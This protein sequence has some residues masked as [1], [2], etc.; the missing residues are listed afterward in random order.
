MSEPTAAAAH[1][2]DVVRPQTSR[3]N[4]LLYGVGTL[5][6]DMTYTL[7]AFFLI[8][9]LTDVV[10]VDNRTLAW[11]TGLLLTVRL[12]DAVLDPVIGALVDSTRTRWGQFKPWMALGGLVSGV[13]TILLFT[14]FGLTGTQFVVVFSLLNLLWGIGW[15]AHDISYWGLLP[16]LSLNPQDRERNAATAKVFASLGQFTVV[17]GVPVVAAGIAASVGGTERAWQLVAIGCSLAMV[18]TMGITIFGVRERTDVDLEGAHTGL[19]EL[20][21]A[22]FRND[23]LIWA[24]TAYLLFMVGYGL[25]GAFGLYFFKYAYGDETVFSVFVIF[26]GIGQVLG[27]ASFPALVRRFGRRR[28]YRGATVVI[29][30][31]FIAFA[32]APLN[33]L[34]LGAIAVVM[35]FLA[36]VIMLLM[37]VFQADTIEYGQWRLGQ[38]NGAVTFA[39][40]PFINKVSG[41]TNT[42]IVGVVAIVSGM[43]EAESKADMTDQGQLT[44][45]LAMVI[46]PAI[47]VAIGYVVWRRK[48]VIDETLHAR[49]VAELEERGDLDADG[50][51]AL[52]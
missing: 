10:D 39:L 5:G 20:A 33:L 44:L 26:V 40:Q 16:A 25:P 14:D 23:Q 4:R 45:R 21:R 47:L 2:P 7:V 41:A 38:R 27:Q 29:V 43:N 37:L 13:F 19:P 18:L 50:R 17:A 6:R 35:F 3:R 28:L 1:V 49:I 22:L 31:S 52:L 36:S 24:A 48:Y 8:F 46:L 30:V 51:R 34:V 11:I 42:A 12:V 32:L 9:Y 15:A